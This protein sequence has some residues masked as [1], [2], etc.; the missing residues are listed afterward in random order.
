M[1]A[2]TERDLA[3]DVK[4]LE[5]QVGDIEKWQVEVQHSVYVHSV[6]VYVRV[7]A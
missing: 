7:Y 5:D 2:R 1:S 6:Y 4:I 3:S